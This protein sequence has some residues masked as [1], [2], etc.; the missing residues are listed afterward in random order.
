MKLF[1]CSSGSVVG[2]ARWR[3]AP[4]AAGFGLAVADLHHCR[5]PPRQAGNFLLRAQKKVTKEEGLKTNT[6]HSFRSLRTPGPAG[7]WTK[8]GQSNQ[9]P[10]RTLRARCASPW[11]RQHWCTSARR[12]AASRNGPVSRWGDVRLGRPVARWAG[13]AERVA[14]VDGFAFRPSSLV[15]FFW[16]LRRKLPARRGGTRQW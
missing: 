8:P 1:A 4:A 9:Q 12:C 14:R 5:V 15:T 10:A 2:M 6:P 11:A 7:H 3:R 13:R 16:A